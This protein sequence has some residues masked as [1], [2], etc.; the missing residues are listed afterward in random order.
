MGK[1]VDVFRKTRYDIV[2]YRIVRVTV[3][4]DMKGEVKNSPLKTFQ[5]LF[6]P[7]PIKNK[8]TPDKK[9]LKVPELELAE[10]NGTTTKTPITP[11]KTNGTSTQRKK[12]EKKSPSR[13]LSF[14]NGKKEEKEEEQ[15]QNSPFSFL[16]NLFP[17]PNYV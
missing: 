8:R 4:D 13:K 15:Q 9:A 12:E 7:S 1:Q 10:K 11:P 16:K 5:G 3:N 6:Q 17:E 14:E 2:N